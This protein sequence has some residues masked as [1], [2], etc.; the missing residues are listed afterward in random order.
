MGIVVAGN[1]GLAI[2]SQVSMQFSS[3]EVRNRNT[4]LYSLK[5]NPN[6][7]TFDHSREN[8]PG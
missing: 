5:H 1:G 4:I 6:N 8:D 3:T 2:E 7:F